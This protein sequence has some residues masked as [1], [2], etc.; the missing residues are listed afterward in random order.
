VARPL[1]WSALG[2]LD[3]ANGFGLAD[4]LKGRLPADPWA[5]FD[6]AAAP[7]APALRALER[8]G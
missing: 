2:R 4:L 8:L 3:R 1:P 5:G 7:L 6:A